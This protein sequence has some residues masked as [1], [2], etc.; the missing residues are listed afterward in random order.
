MVTALA[1]FF[2]IL[3]MLRNEWHMVK[4]RKLKWVGFRFFKSKIDINCFRL[5]GAYKFTNSITWHKIWRTFGK[6]ELGHYPEMCFSQNQYRY[7]MNPNWMTPSKHP[8]TQVSARDVA[9]RR[10]A[11]PSTLWIEMVRAA[12]MPA[13]FALLNLF[14]LVNCLFTLCCCFVLT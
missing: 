8:A 6:S 12:C 4:W 10:D 2:R 3:H 5:G 14:P 1:H 13:C 7:D 11:R 9:P